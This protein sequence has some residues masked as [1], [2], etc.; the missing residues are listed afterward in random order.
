MKRKIINTAICD[1]R[2]VTEE[3][4]TGYD[5]ITINA[6]ALINGARSKELLDKY[7]VKVNAGNIIEVPDDQKIAMQNINGKGEIGPDADGTGVYLLV[8]GRLTIAEGSLEAVRS[9]FKITVNG[10]VLMPAGYMGRFPNL[11]VCGRAEYYPDGAAILKAFTRIDDLFIARASRSL[12]YCSGPLFFLD[13]GIDSEKLLE[14]G[15]RFAA[16]KIVIAESLL[17]R[18]L[19]LFDEETELVRVPDG[20][21]FI[22][23]ALELLPKAIRKYGTKLYVH[24]D[25][26]IQNAEALSS[27]EYLYAD[28]TVSVNTE[29]EDAF[30]EIESVCRE[31]KLIDPAVGY[32]AGRPSVRIG[33]A[34]LDTYPKGL[35]VDDC[36]RVILSGELTEKEVLEKLRIT[37]CAMVICP[38]ELESAVSMIAEDVAMIRVSDPDRENDEDESQDPFSE[39]DENTQVIT[40]PEYRM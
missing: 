36:A 1:A 39:S 5:S 3:S 4:L 25:V 9:Y 23:G 22:E 11:S 37:D 10:K 8:N 30:D 15:F 21:R 33:S 29:L 32:I 2:N 13:T 7:S 26:M 16:R 35:E 31:L 12:Y 38:K 18:L 24:G 34:M 14:K 6:G 27:L 20:T 28:G 17:G 40:A 19:P